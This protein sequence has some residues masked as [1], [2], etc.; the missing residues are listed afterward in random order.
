[1]EK[2]SRISISP[3]PLYTLIDTLK[4][5]FDAVTPLGIVR[6]IYHIDGMWGWIGK[7]S[8]QYDTTWIVT[9]NNMGCKSLHFEMA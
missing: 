7:V 9:Y 6:A 4:N 3:Q 8:Y 1:M 2:G 5:R